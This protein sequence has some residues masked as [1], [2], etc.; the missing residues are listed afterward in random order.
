MKNSIYTIVL[1][2]IT[3]L[4]FMSFKSSSKNNAD[5]YYCVYNLNHETKTMFISNV[6]NSNTRPNDVTASKYMENELD[7]ELNNYRNTF[8][9]NH[10]IKSYVYDDRLEKIKWAKNNDFKIIKFNV[11]CKSGR[12]YTVY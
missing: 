2:I 9:L 8:L 6:F 4:A 3:S 10:K 5:L 12:L 11:K 1:L 7:Y